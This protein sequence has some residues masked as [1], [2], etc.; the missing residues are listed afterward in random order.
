[1]TE[2][3][4]LVPEPA[5]ADGE[6]GPIGER[7]NRTRNAILEASRTLF[8]ERGYSGTRINNITDACGI[9]RAGFYTYF[10]DKREI[11]NILGSTAYHDVVKV[12]ARWDEISRPCTVEEVTEWVRGY[13]EYLDV[14]GAFVFAAAQSSELEEQFRTDRRRMQ[15]RV[16]FMLGVNLR[17][18]Q[19]RPME[20]PEALGLAVM[21]MLDRSWLDGRMQ[22]L[23][24]GDRDLVKTL[25]E[26]IMAI[27]G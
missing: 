12:V 21:A 22:D 24:I 23:P 11:F 27:I 18:R 6:E 10:K 3:T 16:M 13:F 7:A 17:S 4:Q 15:M 8:L 25:A 9:S 19:S 14:H 1:M 26:I 2:D 5:A 20:A